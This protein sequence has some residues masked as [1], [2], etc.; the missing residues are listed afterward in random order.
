M[1]GTCSCGTVGVKVAEPPAFVNDCNCSLCRKV[2]ALWGYYDAAA[3]EVTGSTSG[4]FRT[5]KN[6]ALTE[7]HHCRTCGTT[8]HFVSHHPEAPSMRGVNMNLFALTDLSGVERRYPDGA[9]WDGKSEYA[10]RRDPE[11]MP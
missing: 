2:G 9:A 11:P 5:D 3:I 6:P 4:Y 1:T 7:V 10:F 8:T